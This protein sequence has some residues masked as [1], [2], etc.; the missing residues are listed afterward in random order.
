[1][2]SGV[3]IDVWLGRVIDIGG[4]LCDDAKCVAKDEGYPKFKNEIYNETV[5]I[6]WGGSSYR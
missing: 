1:M 6:R 3:L 4:G 5:K 2:T